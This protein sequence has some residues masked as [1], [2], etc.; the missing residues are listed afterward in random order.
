MLCWG[1]G[2][3]LWLQFGLW[4]Q[5]LLLTQAPQEALLTDVDGGPRCCH[6][7][8]SKT[9]PARRGCLCDSKICLLTFLYTLVHFITHTCS[10]WHTEACMWMD[11][12]KHASGHVV[13]SLLT[14]RAHISQVPH[15]PPSSWKVSA[16]G[17]KNLGE[18]SSRA[19]STL[20]VLKPTEKFGGCQ[21]GDCVLAVA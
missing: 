9:K 13:T 10:H 3:P 7:N 2:G 11:F 16:S 17:R 15:C 12:A 5:T 18:P 8:Q 4:L 21:R 6:G 19:S 1:V 20:Y 14:F